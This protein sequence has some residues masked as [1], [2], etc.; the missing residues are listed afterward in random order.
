MPVPYP[1]P[2]CPL[3][4]GRAAYLLL[5][6]V[7][8]AN[9]M[10]CE[11]ANPPTAARGPSETA[12]ATSPGPE[13][14]SRADLTAQGTIPLPINQTANSSGTLFGITQSG[15]GRNGS[16]TISNPN[17]TQ[18]ALYAQHSGLGTGGWFRILNP[19]ST[20]PALYGSTNGSGLAG[21]FQIFNTSSTSPALYAT[22]DGIGQ[23]FSATSTGLG[24]AGEFQ[25]SNS[26]SPSPALAA[27]T[28]GYG[29]AGQF[30]IINS[31]N[32][33][34]AVSASTDGTGPVISA[35]TTGQGYAGYFS[36]NNNSNSS[37]AMYVT[38]FGTG[39]AG[40]FLGH[41][42]GKGVYIATNGGAGL[43]VVGGSKQAVVPTAG[44]ARSLYTEES[45]EV[46]FTDYGFGQ[47]RNGR[48]RILID[49]VFAQTI[50]AEEPY[51]VFLQA[52]GRAELYVGECTPLGFEVRLKDGD[53][54]IEFSYR[55][56][57]KRRGFE[58]AR[59]EAAPW[60]D[61]AVALSRPDR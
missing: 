49:P 48:A 19:G 47:L 56:V 61:D 3:Q 59:L 6:A 58:S 17:N 60:A 40:Q 14:G 50:N 28:R 10:T 39:W 18:V 16:F 32:N 51:H 21:R 23:A 12:A 31:N 2:A 33:A 36:I 11:E 7:S 44:G 41:S 25:V 1:K 27:S 45:S 30:Q 13:L 43:Q 46:W 24:K 15:T 8:A 34:G 5:L 55:V 38:T 26:G 4:P 29:R 22:T 52:R 42:R 35:A 54:D 53:P 20:A 57:A 37:P 9:L